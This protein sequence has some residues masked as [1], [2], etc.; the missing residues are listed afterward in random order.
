MWYLVYV[1]FKVIFSPHVERHFWISFQI[2]LFQLLSLFLFVFIFFPFLLFGF[3]RHQR[4]LGVPLKLVV[5]FLGSLSG[6]LNEHG[7][8]IEAHHHHR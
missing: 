3:G 4:L 8:L 1:D 7:H 6:L 2:L 5:Q